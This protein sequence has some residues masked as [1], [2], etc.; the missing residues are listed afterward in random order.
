[1]GDVQRFF[2]HLVR[3]LSNGEI[4]RSREPIEIAEIYQS[5]LPYRRFRKA[6]RV[7]TNEDYEM[8]LLR[9]LAGEGGYASVDPAEVQDALIEEVNAVNP[10]PAAFRDYA[11]A[12]VYLNSSA[13]RTL[14]TDF[15]RYAPPP[16][17]DISEMEPDPFD[18]Y[19]PQPTRSDDVPAATR[20]PF[21][22]DPSVNVTPPAGLE[23][24]P[25][26]SET[27][28]HP[29]SCPSCSR[30]LPLKRQVKFCPYCGKDVKVRR[31]PSCHTDL[32]TDWKF[33][34][35]CGTTI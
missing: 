31:C 25:V 6:L 9:L 16:P 20:L 35:T 1:M 11:A 32:A 28:Q 27:D 13:V 7:D 4:D 19:I 26:F 22:P 5:I 8:I 12:K 24:S 29:R 33:C 21:M 30:H 18:S 14:T 10:N 34:I 15:D 17:P 23:Q 3:V 2:G